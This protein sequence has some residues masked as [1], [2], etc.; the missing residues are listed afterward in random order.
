MNLSKK[1]KDSAVDYMALPGLKGK[2]RFPPA[3]SI[4]GN[5][6]ESM[7]SEYYG[8]SIDDMVGR[9]RDRGIVLARHVSIW[10]LRKYTNN[11]LK[12]I[13]RVFN[14]D[15]T[16]AIHAI[17]NINVLMEVDSVVRED[18]RIFEMRIQ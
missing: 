2:Y 9:K 18:V 12:Q 1:R 7:V 3:L 13:A 11:S 15:H 6:I 16:S 8:V 5:L 17:E 4:K 10:L 14:R